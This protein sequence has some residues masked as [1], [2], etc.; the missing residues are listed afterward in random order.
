M[1]FSSSPAY[2]NPTF[3][4]FSPPTEYNAPKPPTPII[5]CGMSDIPSSVV[6]SDDTEG[7]GGNA[8]SPD[9]EIDHPR[10]DK[11][12]KECEYLF[13][14]SAKSIAILRRKEKKNMGIRNRQRPIRPLQT[15]SDFVPYV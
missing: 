11:Q 10:Y 12:P 15:S 3:N 7:V 9:L 8:T 13:C 6:A 5:D 1:T 14:K 4:T 2:C